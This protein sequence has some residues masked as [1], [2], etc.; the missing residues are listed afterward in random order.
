[1]C[2]SIF[3]GMISTF[4]CVLNKLCLRKIMDVTQPRLRKRM[5]ASEPVTLAIL[6]TF[7]CALQNVGDVA[8]DRGP[9]TVILLLSLG[10]ITSK[11][12]HEHSS[13][14]QTL[15]PSDKFSY[16]ALKSWL[17]MTCINKL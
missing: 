16:V 5:T 11:D 17:G 6:P 14:N 1:M 9:F 13:S 7:S 2:W 12:L 4:A 8:C 10:C 15:S 3:V